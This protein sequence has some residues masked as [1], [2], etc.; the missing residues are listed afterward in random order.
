MESIYPTENVQIRGATYKLLTNLL[1]IAII[2][3]L[4]SMIIKQLQLQ[5]SQATA[6]NIIQDL[7]EE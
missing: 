6:R 2:S 7:F 3:H 5:T 4:Q 1:S